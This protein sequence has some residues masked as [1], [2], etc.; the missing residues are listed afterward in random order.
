[1][2]GFKTIKKLITDESR[3]MVFKFLH[4]Q[5]PPYLCDLFMRN[6]NSSLHVLRNTATD[7]KLPRKKSCNGQRCFSYRGAKMWNDL[8]EKTKQASSLYCL[9]SFFLPIVTNFF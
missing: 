7:L 3:I 5:A 6:S 9:F 2:L 8:P 1:M 4:G